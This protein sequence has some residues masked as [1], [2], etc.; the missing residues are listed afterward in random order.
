MNTYLTDKDNRQYFE[1]RLAELEIHA[2]LSL[3]ETIDNSMPLMVAII[4]RLAN[5]QSLVNEQAEE[6]AKL[7][8]QAASKNEKDR[9]RPDEDESIDD[10][11]HESESALKKQKAVSATNL[12]AKKGSA[13]ESSKPRTSQVIRGGNTRVV[14]M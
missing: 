11:K 14:Q 7:K 13:G 12:F 10:E 9:N 1:D 4:R 2:V 8:D 3:E 6:I 5:L